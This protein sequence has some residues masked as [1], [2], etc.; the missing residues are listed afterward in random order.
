VVHTEGVGDW[1]EIWPTKDVDWRMKAWYDLH[2]QLHIHT[3]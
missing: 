1:T 3:C 2:Y